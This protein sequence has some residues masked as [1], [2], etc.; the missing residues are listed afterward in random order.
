L[1][2]LFYLGTAYDTIGFIC[3][4]LIIKDMAIY[5][6]AGFVKGTPSLEIDGNFYVPTLLTDV[7]PKD[8]QFKNLRQQM[9]LIWRYGINGGRK[10]PIFNEDEILAL[11]DLETFPAPDSLFVQDIRL[12][13]S[14]GTLTRQIQNY[15]I[16]E[17]K[18][19]R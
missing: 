10:L 6:L 13:D 2:L 3:F 19:V 5:R 7:E 14:D 12:R 15:L 4:I 9:R 1:L 16:E 8:S 18:K 17:A 11:S